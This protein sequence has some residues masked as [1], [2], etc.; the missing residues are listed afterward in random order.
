MCL[1]F[2]LCPSQTPESCLENTTLMRNCLYFYRI[3]PIL[4]LWY[5]NFT[6]IIPNRELLWFKYWI[7]LNVHF[8]IC[9]ENLIA[10]AS[11]G[12]WNLYSLFFQ[13]Q[14]T[15]QNIPKKFKSFFARYFISGHTEVCSRQFNKTVPTDG[16]NLKA[17]VKS[18]VHEN[19]IWTLTRSQC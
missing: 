10:H 11:Y 9:N 1:I 4:L 12:L 8:N 3:F 14:R 16:R 15:N 17:I 6:K 7:L 13:D 18:K 5:S 2:L 19:E